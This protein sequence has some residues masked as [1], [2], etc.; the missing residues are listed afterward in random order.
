M[1]TKRDV[2]ENEWKSIVRE[3]YR[4]ARKEK[5]PER[6]NLQKNRIYR[7]WAQKYNLFHWTVKDSIMKGFQM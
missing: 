1:R 6:S 5:W 7:R 2:P 3:V 4:E